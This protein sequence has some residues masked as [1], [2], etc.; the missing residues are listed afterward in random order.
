MAR[1]VHQQHA[2]AESLPEAMAAL[3]KGDITH[4]RLDM[5]ELLEEFQLNLDRKSQSYRR[6]GMLS[7]EYLA[8]RQTRFR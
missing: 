6:L 1:Q 3:A 7:L 8:I 5:D 2:L 4:V